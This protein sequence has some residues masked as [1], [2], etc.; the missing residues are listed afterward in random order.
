[1]TM[2]YGKRTLILKDMNGSNETKTSDDRTPV[3]KVSRVEPKASTTKADP[4]KGGQV[5]K[6]KSIEIKP[7][8]TVSSEG[9]TKLKFIEINL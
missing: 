8:S 4:K 6:L 1:M 9:K 3:P 7:P 5:E 2:G